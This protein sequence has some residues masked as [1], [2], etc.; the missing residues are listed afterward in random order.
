MKF[1]NVSIDLVLYT[2]SIISHSFISIILNHILLF[3][4]T[5][6]QAYS[7]VFLI[8]T[9]HRIWLSPMGERFIVK[10]DHWHLSL[11]KGGLCERMGLNLGFIARGFFFKVTWE[12]VKNSSIL[13]LLT[14][15]PSPVWYINLKI[16]RHKKFV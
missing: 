10:D 11:F 2:L 1:F 12:T 5:L 9:L 14:H 16:S 8:Q 6:V 13:T 15:K 3:A 4:F 7:N